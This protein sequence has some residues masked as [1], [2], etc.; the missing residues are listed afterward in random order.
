M[1][2]I[3]YTTFAKN[4]D[5]IENA[6]HRANTARRSSGAKD[7]AELLADV[8]QPASALG[9]S[10]ANN[11]ANSTQHV[12]GASAI[13]LPLSNLTLGEKSTAPTVAHE[14]KPAQTAIPTVSPVAF[15]KSSADYA[16][17]AKL[18]EPPTVKNLPALPSTP[19]ILEARMVS[20]P[21]KSAPAIAP[22]P[23]LL[24]NTPTN[25]QEF[26]KS[27][28]QHHGIDPLLGMAVARAESNFNP[29]AVSSDGHASKG[30][31]QLLDATGKEM[32]D[33]MGVQGR[34]Q[35][36]D[37]QQ[38]THLGMGYLRRLHNLFSDEKTLVGALRTHPASSAAD[39]EKLAV[40]AFNAGEGNV[41]R[42]QQRAKALGKDPGDYDAVKPHLP[43]ITQAYVERVLNTKLALGVTSTDIETV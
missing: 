22:Q 9:D 20:L 1:S 33:R 35:P 16:R 36:F 26:I 31:F 32:M 15:M 14:S 17:L 28:G 30:L 19:D 11:S 5:R 25:Y 4:I 34:Y 37:A 18:T 21:P 42:A 24:S 40:A 41:A 10:P 38:N 43:K 2:V 6:N 29:A 23:R 13:T 27:A 8:E 39:L 12:A 7:F 3:Y